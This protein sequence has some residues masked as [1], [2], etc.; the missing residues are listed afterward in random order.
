VPKHFSEKALTRIFHKLLIG[1][2]PKHVRIG[3]KLVSSAGGTGFSLC[4]FD[5]LSAKPRTG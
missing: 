4:G 5:F 1:A 3:N 2:F